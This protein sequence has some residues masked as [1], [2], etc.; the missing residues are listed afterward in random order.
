MTNERQLSP[1]HTYRLKI[2]R[3]QMTSPNK[4]LQH[5]SRIHYTQDTLIPSTS[6]RVTQW[7][8][9]SLNLSKKSLQR[10]EITYLASFLSCFVG[11]FYAHRGLKALCFNQSLIKLKRVGIF[12]SLFATYSFL[13][14]VQLYPSTQWGICQ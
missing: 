12:Y 5:L 4:S 11:L 9:F 7:I 2:G 6:K 8:L 13:K 1:Y 14:S 3:C 10:L